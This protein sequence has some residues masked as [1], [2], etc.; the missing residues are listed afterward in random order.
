M[1][2]TYAAIAAL[3][4]SA[5]YAQSID[6]EVAQLPSCALT[7][8]STASSSAGCTLTDFACQCGSAKDAIT[9]SATP[10]VAAACSPAD[11]LKVSQLTGQICDLQAAAASSTAPS[12]SATQS[13][14]SSAVH[15]L[16]S[17][18]GGSIGSSIASAT[19]S[20]SSFASPAKSTPI[21]KG[22]PSIPPK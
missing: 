9:K 16:T 17:S 15:S 20:A 7:C 6:S 10:C 22:I 14:S 4:A 13:A 12:S 11:A 21:I 2:F 5:A 18:I 3:L 8:L 1:Y 19:R